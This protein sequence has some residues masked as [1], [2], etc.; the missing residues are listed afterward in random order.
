MRVTHPGFSRFPDGYRTRRQDHVAIRLGRTQPIKITLDT[1]VDV[2]IIN[3][4]LSAAIKVIKTMAMIE[5]SPGKPF[6]NEDEYA[7]GV[8]SAVITISGG[9]VCGSMALT[10]TEPCIKAIVHGLVGIEVTGIDADVKDA[11][12]EL[13]NMI[14][15]DARAG[16]REEGFFLKAAI[17]SIVAG[18]KH[19]IQH[20]VDGPRLAIPFETPHGPFTVEIVMSEAIQLA[21]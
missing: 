18:E 16:L 10:F 4:F 15:G 19:Q 8:V 1:E 20:M 9:A 21:S 14:C 11:V 2:R 5:P 6:L 12:G 7:P 17:P 3:P 13:T